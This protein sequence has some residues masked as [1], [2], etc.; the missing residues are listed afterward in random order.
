MAALHHVGV[1]APA[2]LGLASSFS[3]LVSLLLLKYEP[4]TPRGVFRPFAK[5]FH[6]QRS[7]LRG[8]LLAKA[9]PIDFYL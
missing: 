9:S 7:D 6:T 2:G 5:R 1:V 8:T 3:H 4:Q